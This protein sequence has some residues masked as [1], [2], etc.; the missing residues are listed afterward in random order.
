VA[1]PEQP[2]EYASAGVA[3]LSRN[4][5]GSVSPSAIADCAGFVPLLVS[6][7]TRV[8]AAPSAIDAA[9]NV[10]AAFGFTRFTTRH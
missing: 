1:G 8:V 9:P 6:V 3:E 2:A 5:V 7:K 10:F 4:P